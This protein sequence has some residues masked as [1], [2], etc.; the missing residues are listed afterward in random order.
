A[1]LVD[2]EP[3]ASP[4]VV[5]TPDTLDRL[6]IVH[7]AGVRAE[8]IDRDSR[9]VVLA[10]GERLGYQKVLVAT[11]ATP[12]RLGVAAGC[13]RAHMLRT[14]EDALRLRAALRPGHRVTIIGAGFI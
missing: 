5:L 9:H 7:G 6:G 13:S 10:D 8:R 1:A 2:D 11:G 4:V 12:R 3:P 14:H